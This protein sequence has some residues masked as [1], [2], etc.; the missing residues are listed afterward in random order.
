M[1][2][3]IS[4]YKLK[5]TKLPADHIPP[6]SVRVVIKDSTKISFQWTQKFETNPIENQPDPS[7]FGDSSDSTVILL[8][9]GD[10]EYET[11]DAAQSVVNLNNKYL[12]L[13]KGEYQIQV[14]GSVFSV[15]DQ[16]RVWAKYSNAAPFYMIYQTDPPTVPTNVTIKIN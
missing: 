6:A 11:P 5:I 1:K 10:F 9:P 14:K 7:V 16:A 15:K 2:L 4:A 12:N 3:S 8:L 13:S